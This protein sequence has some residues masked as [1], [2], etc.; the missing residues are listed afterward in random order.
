MLPLPQSNS[1]AAIQMRCVAIL[2][3]LARTFVHDLFQPTYLIPETSDVHTL[4]L[5]QAYENPAKAAA[6]RASL[7]A[8]LP[9]EQEHAVQKRTEKACNTVASLTNGLLPYDEDIRYRSQ[10]KT[11]AEEASQVWRA[12]CCFI[13]T[14]EPRFDTRR[15]DN[16]SDSR[17]TFEEK[18][19]QIRD[20]EPLHAVSQDE[21][22]L[23]IFPRLYAVYEGSY[24][25]ETPGVFLMRSQVKAAQEE[26]EKVPSS[27]RLGRAISKQQRPRARHVSVGESTDQTANA[28]Q[29]FLDPKSGDD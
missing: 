8:L 2:A 26:L 10:L 23:A 7:Q 16:W 4:L 17:F 19:Y 28:N 22:I 5:R 13:D 25:L 11:L 15:H 18:R 27:P 29:S 12:I 6:F 3:H 1:E 14:I 24:G 9:S 21:P 20:P